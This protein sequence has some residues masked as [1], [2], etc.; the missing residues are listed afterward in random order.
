MVRGMVLG[1][2]KLALSVT[3][4]TWVAPSAMVAVAGVIDTVAPLSVMVIVAVSGVP[5][6]TPLGGVPRVMMTVSPLSAT[7]SSVAL[8]VNVAV[9]VL[10][11]TVTVLGTPV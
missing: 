2:V 9:L 7:P 10:A 5:A 11:V 6:V 3:V 8:S 1:V 4:T